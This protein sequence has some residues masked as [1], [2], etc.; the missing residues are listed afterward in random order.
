MPIKE[1]HNC[2][3]KVFLNEGAQVPMDPFYCNRCHAQQI[4]AHRA[5]QTVNTQTMQSVQ[6]AGIRLQCP[7]CNTV[8]S[9]KAP[10]NPARGKCPGCS[11]DLVLTPEGTIHRWTDF[12]AAARVIESQKG[13][14]TGQDDIIHSGAHP[15]VSVPQPETA[16]PTAETPVDPVPAVQAPKQQPAA[17]VAQA[18]P[19][20]EKEDSGMVDIS[21]LDDSGIVNMPQTT[22]GYE[23]FA[24]IQESLA[25]S[26]AAG[27][28]HA[29]EGPVSDDAPTLPASAE[30]E[31]SID[32]L[33]EP[34]VEEETV[35]SDADDI[36]DIE[37]LEETAAASSEEKPEEPMS[38]AARARARAKARREA[39]G[40]SPRGGRDTSTD[41]S[42]AAPG[43]G[44]TV[45]IIL[46]VIAWAASAGLYVAHESVAE[47][48]SKVGTWVTAGHAR[49]TGEAMPEE[50]EEAGPIIGDPAQ[51]V[52]DSRVAGLFSDGDAFLTA[53]REKIGVE[54]A[55]QLELTVD[56]PQ[57]SMTVRG[58]IDVMER[59]RQVYIA[60]VTGESAPEKPADK[61]VETPEEPQD[62]PKEP[63]EAPEEPADA[64]AE[65][66]EEP[67]EAPEKPAE[68]PEEPGAESEE[69]GSS[70]S[71]GD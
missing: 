2:G 25:G 35:P 60:W 51:L 50:P 31:V 28:P 70:E 39:G 55:D 8:F 41:E 14:G 36:I 21:Q 65:P 17:A 9:G 27:L 56:W 20:E 68:T 26:D 18:P 63:Q 37:Q 10:Q 24:D 40:A 58:P 4:A 71:S 59:A 43:K 11:E 1:C 30:E 33:P 34:I 46:F 67:A 23:E 48:L 5:A 62:A 13:T 64:P 69:S 22:S 15:A 29:Q 6:T 45:A 54:L 57:K 19:M 3:L 53:Y 66:V 32:D 44:R 7:A 47:L 38:A 16:S 49:M 42:E 52:I 12:A 61:P